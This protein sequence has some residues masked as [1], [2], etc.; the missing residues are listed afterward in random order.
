MLNVRIELYYLIVDL[1]YSAAETNEINN[2][3]QYSPI[4]VSSYL[5]IIVLIY[6][7]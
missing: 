2:F 4:S 7:S 3:Y 1:F 6:L 5:S